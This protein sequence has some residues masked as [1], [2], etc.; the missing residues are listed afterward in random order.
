MLHQQFR[1]LC[2]ILVDADEWGQ[3]NLLD[4]LARYARTMLSQPDQEEQLVEV[5]ALVSVDNSADQLLRTGDR[6]ERSLP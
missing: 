3:I 5:V 2:R 1:R 4:L 6:R